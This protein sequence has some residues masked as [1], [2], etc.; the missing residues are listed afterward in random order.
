MSSHALRLILILL[1]GSVLS[2]CGSAD[3]EDDSA[4]VA[5]E[6][7]SSCTWTQ[8]RIVAVDQCV[9]DDYGMFWFC[10]QNDWTWDATRLVRGHNA[11]PIDELYALPCALYGALYRSNSWTIKSIDG[12]GNVYG[13]TCWN[14][15]WYD[16]P[17]PQ[18][19]ASNAFDNCPDGC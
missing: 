4:A 10:T 2:A 16:D 8:G 11:C 13:T 15:Q 14:G 12:Q 5:G 6:L 1:V 3:S 7:V 9:I 19:D 17:P 18:G